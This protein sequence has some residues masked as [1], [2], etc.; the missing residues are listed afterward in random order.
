MSMAQSA[1]MQKLLSNPR[2]Q[3]QSISPGSHDLVPGAH[4]QLQGDDVIAMA[5]VELAHFVQEPE[6]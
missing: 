5:E 1:G 3:A 6:D 4:I 2:P